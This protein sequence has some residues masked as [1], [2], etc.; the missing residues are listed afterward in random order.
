MG[1]DLLLVLTY[2]ILDFSPGQACPSHKPINIPRTSWLWLIL[3]AL[4]LFSTIFSGI[5]LAIAS[6]GPRYG[7]IIHEERAFSISTATVL[8]AVFAK[9]IEISFVTVFVA[10]I[11]QVIS[12]RA[13]MKKTGGGITLVSNA[14]TGN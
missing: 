2:E 14:P 10:F 9:L 6:K 13:F 1:E 11:G 8:F 5:Y 12:R 4:S 7:K 3:L